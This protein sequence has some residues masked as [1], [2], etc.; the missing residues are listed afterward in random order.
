MQSVVSVCYTMELKYLAARSD[1][2]SVL[3]YCDHDSFSLILKGL[4]QGMK[5]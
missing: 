4:K 5:D 3:R 1:S 2:L